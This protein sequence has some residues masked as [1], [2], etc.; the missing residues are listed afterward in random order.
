M[1]VLVG[2]TQH[3]YVVGRG[4]A[5]DLVSFLD[6]NKETITNV[7]DVVG[8]VAKAGATSATA[9]RQIYDAV[10]ARKGKG[11]SDKSMDILNRLAK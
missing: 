9:A 5:S 7:A 1:L 11:L 8:S 2:K 10:R 3:K 4:F 6:A